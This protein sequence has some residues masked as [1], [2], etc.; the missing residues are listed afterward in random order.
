M[1]KTEEKNGFKHTYSDAGLKICKVGTNEV[2]DDAMD[3]LTSTATYEETN[4]KI[5]V[6]EEPR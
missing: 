2:Y 1:L 4:I 3:L 6:L 5:E